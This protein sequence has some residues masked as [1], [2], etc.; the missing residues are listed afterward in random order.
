LVTTDG[1]NSFLRI[2]D[3]RNKNSVASQTICLEPFTS[4]S[5]G[6]EVNGMMFS[7]DGIYLALARRVLCRI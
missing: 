4:A 7:P 1:V 6:A 5:E 3:I 2:Y